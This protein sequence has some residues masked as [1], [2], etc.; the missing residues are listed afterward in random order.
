MTKKMTVMMLLTDQSA[1]VGRVAQMLLLLFFVVVLF[2]V[3][4]FCFFAHVSIT[5]KDVCCPFFGSEI[6]V[7]KI[8]PTSLNVVKTKNKVKSINNSVDQ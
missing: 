8:P 1:V 3:F 6:G 4:V 2:L 7:E 5:V